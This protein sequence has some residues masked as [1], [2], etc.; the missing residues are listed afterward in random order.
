MT[1]KV[2]DIYKDYP[3]KVQ[4]YMRNLVD[5]LSRDYKEIPMSWRVS[6]DLIAD[7]YDI[8]LK[9]KKDIDING[10]IIQGQRGNSKNKALA[11]MNQAQTKI[12]QLMDSFALTPKSSAKIK[13]ADK[14]DQFKDELDELIS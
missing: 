7:N 12:I 11:V 9:A 13:K 3:E 1:I 2:E 10:I 6:L 8:Y 4:K 14:S 5:S